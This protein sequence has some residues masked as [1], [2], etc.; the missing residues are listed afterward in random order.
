MNR[1]QA[2]I[3]FL[4]PAVLWVLVFTF[5]PLGYSAVL[6]FADLESKV[7]VSRE[8][9][10]LLDDNGE[11]VLSRVGKPR[12]RT[13]VTRE[14]RTIWTFVGFRNYERLIKDKQTFGAI[15]VTL[16]FAV[17]GVSLQIVIGMALAM[18]FNRSMRGR[19]LM[20]SLMLLPIFAT[21]I[22]VG[23]IFTTI[24]FEEG[25]PLSFTGIPFLSDPTWALV[26]IIIVDVW[27]HSPFAFLVFL[28]G[29]QGIDREQIDAARLETQSGWKIFVHIILPLM[30]P[31]IVIVLLLRLAEAFKLFDIPFLLTGGGPGFATQSYTLFTFKT[32]LRFFDPGYASALSYVLLIGAMIIIVASYS[33]L[34]DQYT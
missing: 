12:T 15:K 24:Y 18:L 1:E 7:D 32:G 23:N 34:R 28:A 31:T 13:I 2:K 8:I 16:I 22:A 25:G 14:A 4:L 11:P 17:A 10:P 9:V 5:F 6:S 33:R 27:Q 30:Q 3:V 26:S 29:L 19:T 20:R 21:P